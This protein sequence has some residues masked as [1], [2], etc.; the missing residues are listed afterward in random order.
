[1]IEQTREISKK[2]FPSNIEK[3]GFI[4]SIA[5]MMETIQSS[6]QFVCSFDIPETIET[7]SLEQKTHLFR[8]VQECTNN[9]I[10]HS[11]ASGLKIEITEKNKE[12]QLI[13]QDN[14]KGIKTKKSASGIGLRSLS[15]RAKLL[16][17]NIFILDEKNA[18]GF[19]LI[20]KFKPTKA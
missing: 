15:E 2:L 10:K 3:I 12:Y 7:L 5:L 18:K 6:S 1:M 13:Y 8:I 14:G 9:T 17:G 4:R 19:K 11:G 20:I 16:N